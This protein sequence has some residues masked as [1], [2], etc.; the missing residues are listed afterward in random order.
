MSEEL[1]DEDFMDGPEEMDLD[2]VEE[3]EAAISFTQDDANADPAKLGLTDAQRKR[4]SRPAVPAAA[5]DPS[6]LGA[7][8]TAGLGQGQAAALTAQLQSQYAQAAAMAA[9]GAGL[10]GTALQQT[11]HARR[12]YIGSLPAGTSD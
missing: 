12:A 4:W 7:A 5:L 10:T 1:F 8:A 11:R 6:S 9:A 2:E 3:E